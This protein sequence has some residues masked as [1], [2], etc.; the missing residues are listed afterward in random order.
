LDFR[1]YARQ[2]DDEL[3]LLEGA[4]LIASD[5]RPGLDPA[6]VSAELDALAG[7]LAGGRLSE[8]PAPLQAR[9][10]ADHLFVREGFHGNSGD[11]Y[12]PKNSFLDEVITRRT[13]IPIS[14][15]V[16]YVE[17][18][19]RVGVWAAPVG[20]PGHYLVRVEDHDRRVVV[21]PFHG[22]GLLDE[23]ELA[24]LLR[25]SGSKLR[26]SSEMIEPTPV[27]QV[28]ARML[29]NLRGIYATRGDYA[30]LL[31]ILDRIVDLLPESIEELRDRG[32]LLGR[33][34][35]PDAAVGDLKRYLELT[36]NAG[37]IPEVRRWI[38]RFEG[39][40][41]RAPAS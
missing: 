16:L 28:V 20:F 27:R 25:R 6:A 30:R 12:D 7:P 23:V 39:A 36:P 8:L 22:G 3:D 29:M 13:G 18:A 9:A 5:A 1:A 37:D 40:S 11:Y 10:L 2:P 38:E 31:V 24:D 21:D 17:V 35:A 15:S 26:Y 33:L 4:L 14:L 34:G 41:R 19:R 32:F